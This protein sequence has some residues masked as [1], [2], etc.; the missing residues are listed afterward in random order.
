MNE[1]SITETGK[2]SGFL[3]KWIHELLSDI[4]LSD[5]IINYINL[6]VLISLSLLLVYLLKDI[7][8]RVI[9]LVFGKISEVG[10]LRILQHCIKNKFA[11]YAGLLI[12]YSFLSATVVYV[13][14]DFPEWI[15]PLTK[16]INIY[17]VYVVIKLLMSVI[18]SFTDS[19]QEK[20]AFENK[21]FKSYLQVI[22]LILYVVGLV[23]IY[24]IL[25]G[26]SPVGLFAAMGAA[27]AVLMLMFQSTIMGFV[28]SIQISS[29]DMARLGDWI[30]MNK[31]GAD[32]TVEEISLTTVKICNFDK[33]ITT[34]PTQALISD[35]FQNW[36]G[37]SESGGRRFRRSVMIK[38]ASIR[39][40]TGEELTK[41]KEIGGLSSFIDKKLK[42]Y[43]SVNATS[44]EKKSLILNGFVITNVMLY[45][46][47]LNWYLKL[48]P[49]IKKEMT[50]LVRQLEANVTGLP[51]QLYAFT[52]TV[53][54]EYEH[55]TGEV[56]AH[57]VAA[58]HHFGL[59]V[60]EQVS[61]NTSIKVEENIINTTK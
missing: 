38:Q 20:P 45:I 40:V 53:W 48:H 42:E 28:A 57:A 60:F 46:E 4:G 6:I 14:A 32:G 55:V 31:Y 61:D 51:I 49:M 34:I 44:D 47:Y 30:T 35:S 23:A 25:T 36:R 17:V 22:Q 10:S 37:M 56:Y 1:Q 8:K 21:S 24:S 50:L 41:Y 13:F 16:I 52:S 26:K 3:T 7:V 33:T 11:S 2:V 19:L 39:Y 29:N 12:S 58:A 18:E 15:S 59:I 9:K 27:S 54:A 5:N 43:A